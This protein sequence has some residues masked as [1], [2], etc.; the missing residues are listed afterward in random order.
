MRTN[1]KCFR[2]QIQINLKT[3]RRENTEASYLFW[4]CFPK[5]KKKKKESTET[6]VKLRD[7]FKHR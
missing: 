7:G 4:K 1:I 3:K 6:S 2:K 5:K